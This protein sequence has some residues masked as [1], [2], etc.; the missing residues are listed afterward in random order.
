M[1][2]CAEVAP[3]VSVGGLS[4]V[5]YFLPRALSRMGDDVRIFTPKYGKMDTEGKF[6]KMKLLH[7]GL[8]VPVVNNVTDFQL[9]QDKKD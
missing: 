1:F 5:M 2:I 8:K 9:K 4:Q 7:K 6:W 3:F